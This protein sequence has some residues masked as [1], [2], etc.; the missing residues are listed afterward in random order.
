MNSDNDKILFAL[1][2]VFL[3]FGVLSITLFP[4]IIN[5]LDMYIFITTVQ[6]KMLA[7]F[8]YTISTVCFLCTNGFYK[9][10]LLFI[11]AVLV[12]YGLFQLSMYYAN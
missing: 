2:C 7:V 1:G 4:Y 5:A 9:K 3:T 12:C 11:I 8:L 10:Q 6:Y